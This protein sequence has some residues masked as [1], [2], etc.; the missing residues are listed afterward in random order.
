MSG[1]AKAVTV[2]AF[3][4]ASLCACAV[5][6]AQ[7]ATAKPLLN[8]QWSGYAVTGKD[9]SYTSIS[10][11]W[12]E[13]VMHCKAGDAPALSAAWI[14]LGGLTTTSLQQ[15]GVDANCDAKGRAAYFA[16]FEILPDVAHTIP[17]QIRSGDVIAA[18]VKRIGLALL[19]LRVQNQT[20]HWTF[21]RKITWGTADVSSAEWIVEAP[22]SCKRFTCQ[23]SRLANFGSVS[24]HN[25]AAVGNGHRG[26]LAD[27]AWTTTQINLVPCV[28]TKASPRAGAT[29]TPASKGGTNF[30]VAW[31]ADAGRPSPCKGLEGPVTVGVVPNYTSP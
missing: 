17:E 5:A 31:V 16:W 7:P 3:A 2:V 29:P 14:G 20:R 30:D 13:P 11:T 12:A 19:E 21:D 15:V 23:S 24:F 9:I 8:P 18:T 4:V 1:T 27:P 26:S 10:G 25:V 6:H 28:R 22:F